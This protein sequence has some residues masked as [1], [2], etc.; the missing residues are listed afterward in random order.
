LEFKS[1]NQEHQPIIDAIKILKKYIDSSLKHYPV[2][3]NIPTD[4]IIPS[5]WEYLFDFE[6]KDTLEKQ[7]IIDI[8]ALMIYTLLYK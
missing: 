7:R 2:N 5:V 6:R 1:N 8:D 3:E 4:K